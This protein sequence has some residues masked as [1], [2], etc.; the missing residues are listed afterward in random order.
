MT[1]NVFRKS[2][3]IGIIILFIGAS[4][5]PVLSASLA[6]PKE[7]SNVTSAEKNELL[8]ID[9]DSSTLMDVTFVKLCNDNSIKGVRERISVKDYN[10]YVEKMKT[11]ESLEET[12]AVMQEYCIVP[13]SMNLDHFVKVI[14]EKMEKFGFLI[15][16]IGQL[17]GKRFTTSLIPPAF[18]LTDWEI[19]PWVI[20]FYIPNI[21]LFAKSDNGGSGWIKQIFSGEEEEFDT[22][23]YIDIL[24]ILYLGILKMKQIL[25][26]ELATFSGFCVNIWVTI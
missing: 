12:F 25:D 3:V 4:V 15:N 19:N 21:I 2:L 22:D 17:E 8:K 7:V 1:K 24:M 20:N 10:E 5:I 18:C 11:S 6:V 16:K 26:T 14:N 23:N 9:E 13:P